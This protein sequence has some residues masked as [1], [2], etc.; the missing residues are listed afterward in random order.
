MTRLFTAWAVKLRGRNYAPDLS[1]HP[2]LF[3]KKAS[4]VQYAWSLNFQKKAYA[5]CVKVNV[6][7]S[8]TL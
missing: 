8:E 7:I 4:A 2:L 3:K 6:R 1:G 5:E